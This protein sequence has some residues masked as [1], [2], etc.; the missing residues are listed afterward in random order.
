MKEMIEALGWAYIGE[1]SKSCNCPLHRKYK[2]GD[3]LLRH[4][5]YRHYYKIEHKKNTI[6]E[7]KDAGMIDKIKA[8]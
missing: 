6:A 1:S 7:G 4:Y 8:L 2:K 5:Y 3:Y